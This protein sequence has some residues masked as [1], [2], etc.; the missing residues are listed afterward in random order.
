[1]LGPG[2]KCPTPPPVVNKA[3][4]MKRL[5]APPVATKNVIN[6]I[7]T[8][9]TS[10]LIHAASSTENGAMDNWTSRTQ[11]SEC[12]LGIR[13][14]EGRAKLV[15]T[16][17][18]CTDK[19]VTTTSSLFVIFT[20]PNSFFQCSRFK[21]VHGLEEVNEPGQVGCR[22]PAQGTSSTSACMWW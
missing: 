11:K 4:E 12:S 13:L 21:E 5:K 3:R 2:E 14:R 9:T 16:Q 6:T 22:L 8:R 7:N 20:S 15:C 17:L 18:V 1:M 10:L 19:S